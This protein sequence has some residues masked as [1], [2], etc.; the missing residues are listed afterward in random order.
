MP[1]AQTPLKPESRVYRYRIGEYQGDDARIAQHGL[2]ELRVISSHCIER[3]RRDGRQKSNLACTAKHR[4]S[5]DQ[6]S[7]PLRPNE[8]AVGHA[9][10]CK[11][12]LA[13]VVRELHAGDRLDHTLQK[14]KPLSR[15][16][17]TL[18]GFERERQGAAGPIEQ[19]RAV[20][21][22]LCDGEA[23]QGVLGAQGRRRLPETG[24]V[25]CGNACSR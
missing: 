2:H 12:L 22:Q 20:A 10:A 4:S 16:A 8:A 11:H 24:P 15:V 21:E 13:K 18:P 25:R 9:Q 19:T 7:S 3:S 5:A 14:N 17:P 1:T 23:R 6:T